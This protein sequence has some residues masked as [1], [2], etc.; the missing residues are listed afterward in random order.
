MEIKCVFQGGGAKLATLILVAEVL[1]ELENEGRIT[2]TEVAGTSAG[3]IAAYCFATEIPKAIIRSRML[4][5]GSDIIARFTAKRSTTRIVFDILRGKPLYD[6]ALLR[7]FLSNVINGNDN[8]NQRRL[9]DTR[10]PVHVRVS[11]VRKASRYTYPAADT[12]PAEEAL[13]DSCAIPF[14]LRSYPSQ[15]LLYDGG[16]VS[17]L[18]DST[19][20]H[21]VGKNIIAF[22]FDK[23]APIEYSGLKSFGK[24]LISTIIDGNVEQSA[25][26]IQ[27]EGGEICRL[28][29]HFGTFD[30]AA[31]YKDGLSTKYA[32]MHRDLI[33]R[34][35]LSSVN[36]LRD[37]GRR[38][39]GTNR[40][41]NLNSFSTNMI[42]HIA[43]D[44]PWGVVGGAI[45]C[46]AESLTSPEENDVLIKEARIIARG[47]S[48]QVFRLGITKD[49]AFGLGGD[50]SWL[51]TDNDDHEVAASQEIIQSTQ[52]GDRVWHSCF[53]LSEPIEAAR[54]PLKVRL[55]TTHKG[56]MSGLANKHGTE[57]MRAACHQ[58]D[59]VETQDYVLVL[60][61]EIRDRFTMVDLVENIHRATIEPSKSEEMK[62][63]WH[64]GAR[65]TEE[66][67]KQ[68][69]QRHLHLSRYQFIGWRSKDVPPGAYTGALIE[70]R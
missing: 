23:E 7:Q 62:K 5:F 40:E 57:W 54:T 38:F 37:K 8:N 26:R 70:R 47:D 12:T 53:C 51:V 17:N 20:F 24:S 43:K 27:L 15:S 55:I 45:T 1:E 65:M 28:P 16:I 48:I 18:P 50:V 69:R 61:E 63:N 19:V 9:C 66:E 21:D 58:D 36:K 68:Y 41:K 35:I 44:R 2:V 11:N 13:V 67:L 25:E 32:D 49:E 64:G 31:A 42:N 3:S 29:L 39:D 59:N 34:R 6:E 56:L 60:P 46:I 10:I 4:E 22:S 52:N 14:A 33:R 30:F